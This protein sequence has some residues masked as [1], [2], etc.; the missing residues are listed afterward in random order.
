MPRGRRRREERCLPP[1]PSLGPPG[2][3]STPQPPPCQPPAACVFQRAHTPAHVHT[4]QA[5]AFKGPGTSGDQAALT[6]HWAVATLSRGHQDLCSLG[7]GMGSPSCYP[8][9]LPWAKLWLPRWAW[10]PQGQPPPTETK[11]PTKPALHSTPACHPPSS[12][13]RC[14]QKPRDQDL[15]SP[16][17][18]W[19]E[20]T[21]AGHSYA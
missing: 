8:G 5:L 7:Y 6:Q 15:G 1:G 21:V 11:I 3:P 13:L 10:P 17:S 20:G 4:G 19:P 16:Q 18:A 2:F 12:P 9:T 14:T